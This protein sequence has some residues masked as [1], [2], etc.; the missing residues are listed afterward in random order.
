MKKKVGVKIWEVIDPVLKKNRELYIVAPPS[1]QALRLEDVHS[2]SDFFFEFGFQKTDG[3]VE[4]K[5][6]PGGPENVNIVAGVSN[7]E[8]L[9]ENLEQ[10]FFVLNKYS[11]V[12]SPYD[13]PMI[14]NYADEFFE[15]LALVDEDADTHPF[16]LKRQLYLD[17]YLTNIKGLLKEHNDKQHDDIKPEIKFIEDEC[18]SLQ[19]NLTKLTKN[20]V[21]KKL[22]HIWAL[23]R[24]SGLTL[25][26][27]M[28]KE[29]QKQAITAVV[30][31]TLSSGDNIFKL[32]ENL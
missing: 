29:F 2:D 16:D 15:D 6:K 1:N 17:S 24:K 23:G 12:S 27:D 21:L 18:T 26:K 28:L 11:E 20:Q 19:Q 22:S 8:N 9:K 31:G 3:T 10:W 30:K 13:D 4:I 5:Y 14:V 25:L 7:V 32:L